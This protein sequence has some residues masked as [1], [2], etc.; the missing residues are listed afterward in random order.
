MERASRDQDGVTTSLPPEKRT[1]SRTRRVR[2]SSTASAEPCR[3]RTKATRRPSGDTTG[4]VSAQR[5]LGPEGAAGP[6]WPPKEAPA[7]TAAARMPA[8]RATDRADCPKA[9]IKDKN[10][11]RSELEPLAAAAR[12]HEASHCR[13]PLTESRLCFFSGCIQLGQLVLSTRGRSSAS[14]TLRRDT[15]QV[16]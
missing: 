9:G 14:D 2:M 6:A 11:E 13:E 12:H 3:F 10:P 1:S 15:M 4:S 5:S 7:A 16:L 8:A